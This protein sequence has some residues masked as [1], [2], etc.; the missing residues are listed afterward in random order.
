M[1]AR[2]GRGTLWLRSMPSGRAPVPQSKM[3]RSP[4]LVMSSTQRVLPPN[5]TVEGP[6]VAIDPRVPQKRTRM[7]LLLLRRYG[8]G[9]PVCCRLL[10]ASAQLGDLRE[11]EAATGAI[12]I[13]ADPLD[14]GVIPGSLGGVERTQL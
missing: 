1:V 11:A 10:D 14:G 3:S 5:R 7:V 13:V 2:S 6:G 12:Q 8:M 4:E 9:F